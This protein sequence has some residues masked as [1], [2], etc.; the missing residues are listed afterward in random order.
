MSDEPEYTSGP[1]RKIKNYNRGYV[2]DQAE[3]DRR[4]R[5]AAVEVGVK[6]DEQIEANARLIAAAPELLKALQELVEACR[7]Y[8]T[9]D[10]QSAPTVEE[11]FD[12]EFY[13][14]DQAIAKATGPHK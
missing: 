6:T 2:V 8:P 12:S 13:A 10:V 9:A 11:C 4:H 1:W 7:N 3:G 14:A 5:I